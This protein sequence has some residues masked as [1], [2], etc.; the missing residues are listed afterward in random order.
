MID[1]GKFMTVDGVLIHYILF[2]FLTTFSAES[3]SLKIVTLNEIPRSISNFMPYNMIYYS[4][5][6]SRDMRL[7][8]K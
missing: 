3:Q 4:T 8:E 7:N 5:Y 6:D 2:N 1:F